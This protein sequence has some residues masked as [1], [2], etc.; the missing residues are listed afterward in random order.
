MA[1]STADRVAEAIVNLSHDRNDPI[2]NLKLQKLLYYCQAWY[3]AIFKKP[4]FDEEV[5]AWVHG[6]VVPRVFNRYR[7]C[8]WSPIPRGDTVGVPQQVVGHLFKIWEVYGKFSAYDL[9]RI[10]HSEQPWQMARRG[11]LPDESS[12]NVITQDSMMSYYSSRLNV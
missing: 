5:E 8:R 4:L 11:L 6:P 2:S 12:H 3:L 9:E 1:P 10:T 7:V